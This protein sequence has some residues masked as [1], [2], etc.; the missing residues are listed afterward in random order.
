MV[1]TLFIGLLV[2]GG[3][4]LAAYLGQLGRWSQLTLGHIYEFSKGADERMKELLDRLAEGELQVLRIDEYT[5]DLSDGNSIW[6][7]NK[8]YGYGTLYR[9]P[10]RSP[11]R[12]SLKQANRVIKLEEALIKHGVQ[13]VNNLCT[14]GK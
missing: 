11:H 8:Y 7:G 9:F 14:R 4:T 6:I 10:L 3:F 13:G 5:I 12:V 2:V 1:L